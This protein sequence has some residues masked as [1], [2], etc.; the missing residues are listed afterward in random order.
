MFL[1]MCSKSSQSP[2]KFNNSNNLVA[3]VIAELNDELGSDISGLKK[4]PELYR[5]RHEVKKAFQNQVY[6]HEV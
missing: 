3:E 5:K 2:D 6:G 1:R 4:I